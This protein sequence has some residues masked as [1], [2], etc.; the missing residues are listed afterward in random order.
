[1]PDALIT[2]SLLKNRAVDFIRP[3]M[4]SLCWTEGISQVI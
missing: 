2:K 3:V 4:K 1:M